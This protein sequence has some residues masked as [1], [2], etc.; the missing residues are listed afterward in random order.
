MEEEEIDCW[1]L[2]FLSLVIKTSNSFSAT[3]N[4][5]PFVKLAH[6]IALRGTPYQE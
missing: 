3:N 4:K 1:K 2:R 5:S 6:P